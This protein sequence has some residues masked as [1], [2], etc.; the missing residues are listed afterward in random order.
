MSD[1]NY[2]MFSRHGNGAKRAESARVG[3]TDDTERG[4]RLSEA[5]RLGEAIAARAVG[6]GRTRLNERAP[7]DTGFVSMPE[8]RRV[9]MVPSK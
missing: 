8:I 3:P 1:A 7:G 4:R 6:S 2:R 5:R 9:S